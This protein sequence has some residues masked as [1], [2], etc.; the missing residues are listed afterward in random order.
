VETDDEFDAGMDDLL[1]RRPCP[2]HG[3]KK[4]WLSFLAVVVCSAGL[5]HSQTAV[6]EYIAFRVDDH[7]VIA[8]VFVRE[9]TPPQ[10]RDGLSSR[11]AA[12]YGHSHF[13]VPSWWRDRQP[14]DI[15]SSGRWLVQLSAGRMIEAVAKEVVGGYAG[16][17]EAVGVLLDVDPSHSKALAGSPSRYFIA[18][19]SDGGPRALTEP[20]PIGARPVP[21]SPEWRASV[22]AV[23]D[24]L[25]ARELPPVRAKAAPVLSKM[26]ASSVG[27]HRSWARERRRVE[28]ALENN[29]GRRQYDVQAFQLGPGEPVYFVRAEWTVQGRQGFA[30]SLWLRTEPRVDII[31]TNLRPASWLRTFEFQGQVTRDHLGLVLNVLDR[32]R[33]GWGEILFLQSG[34]EAFGIS[35]REFSPTG[36][37]STGLTYGGGC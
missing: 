25:L 12:R 10:I 13:A 19:P 26:E 17:E 27:Y 4:W 1:H 31:E 37:I 15:P 18:S 6:T 36:F 14:F 24:D 34:Y 8:T 30:A 5:P 33:D 28:T 16:C 29:E 11:P 22:E 21:T 20:S 2:H 3:L 7:R 23:L 35:L 9:P 32:D